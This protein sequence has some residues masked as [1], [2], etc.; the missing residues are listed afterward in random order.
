MTTKAF[1]TNSAWHTDQAY[2]ILASLGPSLHSSGLHHILKLHFWWTNPCL[3]ALGFNCVSVPYHLVLAR[4]HVALPLLPLV[5]SS[6][7]S[8]MA[9]Y[10]LL[11]RDFS[12]A[13]L[14][15]YLIFE[16]FHCIH[17]PF[18]GH[19]ILDCY[20]SPELSPVICHIIVQMLSSTFLSLVTCNW[21]L[22]LLPCYL[23][24][25]SS[26]PTPANVFASGPGC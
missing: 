23:H 13:C 10:L 6:V 22:L 16:I 11:S 2:W 20:C 19:D 25:P 3:V 26:P 18:I 7:F 17:H 4:I 21:V 5:S 15:S 8:S 1:V 9:R 24:L 12:S 14:H